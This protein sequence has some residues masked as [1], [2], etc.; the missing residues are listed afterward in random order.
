MNTRGGTI[1]TATPRPTR[2]TRALPTAADHPQCKGTIPTK[3]PSRYR[4]GAAAGMRRHTAAHTRRE[5]HT[6]QPRV[7][8]RHSIPGIASCR[9]RPRRWTSDQRLRDRP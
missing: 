4:R 1:W 7:G 3:G 2:H 6:G 5:Y 8:R 9:R